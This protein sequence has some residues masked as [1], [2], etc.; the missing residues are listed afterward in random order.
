[1]NLKD[2]KLSKPEN[3]GLENELDK[4]PENEKSENKEKAEIQE[5]NELVEEKKEILTAEKLEKDQEQPT[6]VSKE[7]IS[8]ATKEEPTK[9]QDNSVDITEENPN[10]SEKSESSDEQSDTPEEPDIKTE[11]ELEDNKLVKEVEESSEISTDLVTEEKNITEIEKGEGKDKSQSEE[12]ISDEKD[13]PEEPKLPE[14]NLDYNNFSKEELLQSLKDLVNLHPVHRIKNDVDNI[15]ICF[16]KRLKSDNEEKK[17]KF[18]EDG[19]TAEDFQ[20]EPDNLE[21]ELKAYLKRYKELKYDYNKGLEAEKKENLIKKYEIIKQI[22]TLVNTQESINQTF[23]DFKELQRTWYDIGPVPQQELNR[24]W[25]T[26]HHHVERFYDYVNINKELRDLDLKKNF[27]K[28]VNLC[29]RAEELLKEQSPI[30]AFKELQKLHALWREIGPVNRDKKEDIWA[31][32]KETTTFINK[33]HQQHYELIREGQK[34]NLAEKSKLCEQVEEISKL[35]INNHKAWE[36]KSTEIIEIQK[37][38]KTIGFAPL[39]DNNQIYRR[40]RTA[41][42]T[43]FKNKREYYSKNKEIQ[44][45]NLKK[46]TELCINAESFQESTEWKKATDELIKIQKEW[47]EIGPV[48]RKHSDVV[49][50][51]FRKACDTFFDRKSEHFLGLGGEQEENL[52]RKLKVIKSISEIHPSDEHRVDLKQLK[53]FQAE[54]AEIGH[55]PYK[56]KDIVMKKYRDAVEKVYSE[57]KMDDSSKS[58]LRFRQKIEQI[59]DDRR[60]SD[61]LFYEREKLANKLRLVESDIVIWEN[62]IGF[63]AKSKSSEAMIKDIKMKIDKGRK[64]IEILRGKINLIDSI[65]SNRK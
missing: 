45:E 4:N 7:I 36:L 15:K 23:N 59:G 24:L 54:W 43:Y 21:E 35:E 32:F 55:V 58:L 33:A 52:K 53:T 64:N 40:F 31:R 18:L 6:E 44:S 25:E 51:R 48:A 56:E 60:G 13:K 9:I 14:L 30:K 37:I 16:Y 57:L 46:K 19:N 12:T 5:N 29:L 65:E 3:E 38:W 62:N 1:M 34:K 63:I 20:P 2:A 11:G 17:K 42:D 26:Y 41:C 49:W 50:K 39:R 22:S 28:K 8:T 10:Q 61:K 47:K 27:E